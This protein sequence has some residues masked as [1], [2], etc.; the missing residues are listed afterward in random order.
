MILAQALAEYGLAAMLA[1]LRTTIANLEAQLRSDPAP[2]YVIG[3][4]VVL[5]WWL[6][7]KNN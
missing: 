4:V 7:L 2:F 6:F 1:G 3:V 5:I